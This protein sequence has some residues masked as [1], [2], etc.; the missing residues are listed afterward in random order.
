MKK[1]A[2]VLAV[3]LCVSMISVFAACG[4]KDDANNSTDAAN[5]SETA[6]ETVTE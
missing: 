5:P 4:N 2:K 3:V 1:L 6:T